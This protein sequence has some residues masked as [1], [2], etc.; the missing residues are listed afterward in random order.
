VRDLNLTPNQV[1]GFT[2]ADP[3]WS[4]DLDGA[5]TATRRGDLKHGNNAVYGCVCKD[6]REHQRHRMAKNR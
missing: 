4:A 1:W 3:E 5:L 2:K 6:C